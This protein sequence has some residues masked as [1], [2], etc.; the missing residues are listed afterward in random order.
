MSKSSNNTVKKLAIGTAVA[1]AAGYLVG[2]LSAPKAGKKTRKDIK[3]GAEKSVNDLEKQLKELHTELNKLVAETKDEGLSVTTKKKF[4]SA[5]DTAKT[6]KDKLRDVL[7]A[8]HEGE[9]D[10][11]ELDKA[12]K[13]AKQALEHLKSFI[14]K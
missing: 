4:T 8:I 5:V 9:A 14:K 3:K 12:L 10:D 1:G 2:V 13:E 11:K 7:S 6:T